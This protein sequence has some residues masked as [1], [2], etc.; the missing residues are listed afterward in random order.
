MRQMQGGRLEKRMTIIS[1]NSSFDDPVA[2]KVSKT[3]RI[4]KYIHTYC[5]ISLLSLFWETGIA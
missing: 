3:T 5:I 1:I 4:T 2:V